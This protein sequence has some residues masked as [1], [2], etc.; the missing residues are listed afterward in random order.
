MS[1]E[2]LPAVSNASQVVTPVTPPFK[3]P[4]QVVAGTAPHW[5]LEPGVMDG[6]VRMAQAYAAS[7]VVPKPFQGKPHDCFVVISAAI[8]LKIEPIMAFQCLFMVEGKLGM[9][10]KLC[11]SLANQRGPWVGGVQ[12]EQSGECDTLAVT[13]FGVRSNGDKDTCTISIGQAKEA[14]WTGRHPSWKFAPVQRLSYRAATYLVRKYCPE[15]MLGLET[16]EEIEDTDPM[17]AK[18]ASAGTQ[19]L[20]AALGV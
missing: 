7:G 6:L 12:F 19:E 14:G 10:G 18:Q 4:A 5:S 9:D 3:V 15:V 8:T 17:P 20:N 16:R 11:I 1:E 2:T 13:A